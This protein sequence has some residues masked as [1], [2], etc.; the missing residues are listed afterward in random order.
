MIDQRPPIF[1]NQLLDGNSVISRSGDEDLLITGVTSDSR[2]VVSGNLF[3]AVSGTITDGHHFIDEAWQRGASVVV[4]D[5]RDMFER[6]K[7]SLAADQILCLVQNSHRTLAQLAACW[8]GAPAQSLVMIG[9]T[10]T[11]G[12]TTISYLLEHL[13]SHAGYRV[14]VIS[15]VNYRFAGI[16]QPAAH[17]TPGPEE[18]H[19][20]LRRMVD[21][22]ADCCV[23]EVSSHALV[24]ERVA[25]ISFSTVVFTNLSH[26]HLD[27]HQE[28]ESYFQAKKLLFTG[29]NTDAF[30]VI[31]GDDLWG[32]RLL[33]EVKS[34]KLSYGLQQGAE[35]R[36]EKLEFSSRGTTFM[37]EAEGNTWECHSPLIG[38]YN[39]ANVLAALAVVQHLDS[40]M[41][42]L[43]T[44]I[45]H[46]QQVPG[47][48]QRV[49]NQREMH[50]F[51]D[52]AHT[53]DALEKVLAA[54]KECAVA[55]RL[56]ILFG[57]GGDRDR[58]KRPEMGR[59]A[60]CYSDLV[61]VTSDNPRHENP[62]Q[63]IADILAGMT[64]SPAVMVENNR[65]RAIARIIAAGRPGD[66]VLLAGKGHETYQQI[67][68]EKFPF[69]DVQVAKEMLAA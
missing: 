30:K 39:V 57:C 4:L 69:D 14:G 15:T 27:Y 28:M 42:H 58:Q 54:L 59:I 46:F 49:T 52:Y 51:V 48:L 16:Q 60:Q 34:P 19:A 2:Q 7:T 10:G 65:R 37:I 20:L 66:L 26:E 8:Y 17:T 40:E 25:A 33:E 62:E 64:M 18:L 29:L 6:Y 9:V 44:A 13:L 35:F 45:T 67:G 56:L 61:V 22:G 63:I 31:N 53:P 21:A 68:D 12:K 43:L 55:G 3:V 11:N 23:L 47:R 24:Q 38:R 50:I 32:R 1:L 36:A 41:K 5:N